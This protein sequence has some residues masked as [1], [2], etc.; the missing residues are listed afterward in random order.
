M[1]EC[2]APHLGLLR[3]RTR[4]E[5]FKFPLANGVSVPLRGLTLEGEQDAVHNL[6]HSKD[7]LG[8]TPNTKLQTSM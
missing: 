1:Y 7:V 2:K 4:T 6:S 5:C 3:L 8:F